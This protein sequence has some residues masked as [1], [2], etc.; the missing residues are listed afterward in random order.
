MQM[1]RKPRSA[2]QCAP[3]AGLLTDL[4]M[5]SQLSITLIFAH[6]ILS[7]SKSLVEASFA[8]VVL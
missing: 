7:L 3:S 8:L 2:K 5:L 6:G 4:G 1:I